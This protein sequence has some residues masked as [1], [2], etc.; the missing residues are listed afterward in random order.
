MGRK[1][2]TKEQETFLHEWVPRY[3]QASEKKNYLVLW[4]ELF[5]AWF[6]AFPEAVPAKLRDIA[7]ELWAK[8]EQEEAQKGILKRKAQLKDWYRNHTRDDCRVDASSALEKWIKMTA[9][10][11]SGKRSKKASEVFSTRYYQGSET[12]KIVQQRLKDE[13]PCDDDGNPIKEDRRA[14]SSRRMKIYGAEIEKAWKD[15]TDE[16]KGEVQAAMEANKQHEDL[17]EEDNE[18]MDLHGEGLRQLPKLMDVTAKAM[19]DI[20]GWNFSIL[21]GGIGPTGQVKTASY[22]LGKMKNGNNFCQAYSS[23]NDDIMKP[24]TSFVRNVCEETG[25]PPDISGACPPTEKNGCDEQAPMGIHPPTA[26]PPALYRFSPALSVNGEGSLE[27][28][29]M[30]G[31]SNDPANGEDDLA[32]TPGLSNDPANGEDDLARTPGLV[33]NPA[34]EENDPACTPGHSNNPPQAL[35]SNPN[36]NT[37]RAG[38]SSSGDTNGGGEPLSPTNEAMTTPDESNPLRSTESTTRSVTSPEWL[39][40]ALKRLRMVKGGDWMDAVGIWANMEQ[41]AIP[42]E[43]QLRFSTSNRP[44]QVARWFAYGRLYTT[45][46]NIPDIVKYENSLLAWWLFLQPEW[47]TSEG[48]LPLALYDAPEGS[49]WASLNKTGPD[50]LLLVMMSF[51]WWGAIVGETTSW[52]AASADLKH[53]LKAMATEQQQVQP[54][55]GATSRKRAM[56]DEKENRTSGKQTKQR[57]RGTPE[58]PPP[59]VRSIATRRSSQKAASVASP[60][61]TRS[62]VNRRTSRK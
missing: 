13:A 8:E 53:A 25:R 30:P 21:S 32:R 18:A 22:H 15:A 5:T 41:S 38:S 52:L 48:P 10:K 40:H 7:P 2:T 23:F 11:E 58:D 20:T 17:E 55:S 45:D 12:Q 35:A 29:R 27:P 51:A 47:R 1:W 4:D 44:P 56:A 49:N 9:D 54:V 57:Q 24:W 59:K 16:Q 39:S 19:R 6:V 60:H 62:A 46:P 36:A 3:K 28:A 61:S 42:S 14:K 31:L 43:K 33:D 50:G 34:N 37:P 26:P